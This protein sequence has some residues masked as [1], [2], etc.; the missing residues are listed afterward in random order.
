MARYAGRALKAFFYVGVMLP[1]WASYI[2]KA[3]AWRVILA[4]QGVVCW[5][6]S[7]LG[8]VGALEHALAVPVVGGIA[9][10]VQPRHARRVHVRVAA[11]HDPADLAAAIERVPGSLLQASADLG[12][13]PA[14]RF[15]TSCC[16]SRCPGVV[17]GSIFTF[18]LT[19]GD[20]I[21][22]SWS[23]RPAYFIGMMVYQQQG[24][25]GNSAARGGVLPSCRS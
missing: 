24:T 19:L 15:R 5:G 8:L 3:Y 14:R 23:A 1:M 16:R 21:I 11:V 4:K 6:S 22:P 2:V 10:Y 20:Y 25:A 18:S 9:L 7:M 17:G 12:A 13:R